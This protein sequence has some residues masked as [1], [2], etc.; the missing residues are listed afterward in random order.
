MRDCYPGCWH[1]SQVRF[2]T[3]GPRICCPKHASTPLHGL[4]SPPVWGCWQFFCLPGCCED[5]VL[6]ARERARTSRPKPIPPEHRSICAYSVRSE[7]LS[8]PSSDCPNPYL[9]GRDNSRPG[10]GQD[11]RKKVRRNLVVSTD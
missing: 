5:S 1:F 9:T 11:E 4:E 8:G 3:S 10:G 2:S 7:V 6:L